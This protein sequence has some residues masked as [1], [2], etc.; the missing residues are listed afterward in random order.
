MT[1]I[2]LRDKDLFWREGAD[3][4]VALDTVESSYLSANPSAA[5]LWKRLARGATDA[6]LADVLCERYGIA[7]QVAEADVA[8]FLEELSSHG[9]LDRNE[10]ARGARLAQ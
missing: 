2:R 3:E 9:L 1:E 8:A 6:E 5:L 10:T 4:I 7:R